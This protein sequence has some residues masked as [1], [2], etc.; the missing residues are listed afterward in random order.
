MCK[1]ICTH[2]IY[3]IIFASMG[4]IIKQVLEE[5]GITVIELARR[6]GV[7]RGACYS[8]IN[9][10]PTVD[11]LQRIANAI[12]IDIRDLFGSDKQEATPRIEHIVKIDGKEYNIGDNDF[13]DYIK[14]KNKNEH[15]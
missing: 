10:N 5:K 13:I 1:S 14:A 12:N 11:C 9:G 3:L 2:S 6:L 15:N 8:Y 4:L 7:T